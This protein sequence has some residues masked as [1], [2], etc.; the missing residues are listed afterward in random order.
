[1]ET[2]R[3]TVLKKWLTGKQKLALRPG[4]FVIPLSEAGFS[5][6]QTMKT[7]PSSI[8]SGRKTFPCP[9][10]DTAFPNS[11]IRWRRS[12]TCSTSRHDLSLHPKRFPCRRDAARWGPWYSKDTS[13]IPERKGSAV[14]SLTLQN[15]GLSPSRRRTTALLPL[16]HQGSCF[17]RVSASAASALLRSPRQN[18]R[19]K[20]CGSGDLCPHPGQFFQLTPKRCNPGDLPF[21]AVPDRC[22]PFS[23]HGATDLPSPA[24]PSPA[25]SGRSRVR[26]TI[27]RYRK[28]SCPFSLS[29]IYRLGTER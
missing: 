13:S 16:R 9:T 3:R 28:S 27:T 15:C 8:L 2:N 5:T 7:L 22:R 23:G 14:P 24:A 10:A 6:A 12:K 18:A 19:P 17:R 11:Y 21:S 25:A 29:A 1:M 26:L 4:I 20:R